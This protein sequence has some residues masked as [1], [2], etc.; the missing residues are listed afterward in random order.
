MWGFTS[1]KASSPLSTPCIPAW[2]R[3]SALVFIVSYDSN[4]P[5]Q[6]TDT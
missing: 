3:A 5:A 1:P 2:D 6:L 4:M